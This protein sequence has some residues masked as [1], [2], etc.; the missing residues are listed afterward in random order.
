MKRWLTIGAICATFWANAETKQVSVSRI[1]EKVNLNGELDEAFW[2]QCQVLSD[3]KQY[4]PVAGANA[5]RQT[6][7]RVVY[8]NTAIYIGAEMID[9]RDSMSLTL[10]QRDDFGNADY[11]GVIVD[12]YNAGTIG[13]AFFVTSSGVQ[14]DQLHESSGPDNNWNAVWKSEVSVQDDRWTAEIKIPFSAI[15]FPKKVIQTWGINFMRSIRRKREDSYWNFYDPKGVNLI[16]QLGVVHGIENVD[17][18]LR[19]SFSPYV[20]GYVENFDGNTGYTLNG[21]MDLKYGLNEAFTLDM[22]LIPDFGQVQFDNQVLNLSPFEVRFNENRQFFTEGTELFNK[23]GLFYSRRVGGAPLF[24]NAAFTALDSN[25]IVRENPQT[26][27]LINATKLSGRTKTGTGIALFNAV[28]SSVNAVLTDTLTQTDRQFETGP[29]SN[30]NVFVIDQNL[31]NNSTVT[32]TNTNVMRN[33]HAYD[34]NVTALG[35][36]LYTKNLKYNASASVAFSQL[37]GNDSTVFGYKTTVRLAKSRGNLLWRLNYGESN[38]TYNQND[39]GFQQN[40]NTRNFSALINYNIFKPFWRFYRVWSS[41]EATYSRLVLPNEYASFGLSGAV[42]GTFRNFMTAGIWLEAAPLPNHDWFEPRQVGR[43][44]ETDSYYGAGGFISSDYS[45]PFALDLNVSYLAFLEPQRYS[46]SVF[47]SPRVRASDRLMII[48]NYNL[49]YAAN[50]EGAALTR[51]FEVPLIGE[52]PVFAKR[53]RLTMVNGIAAD[54]IFTNR[55][56]ITFSLRHYWSKVTYNSFYVLNEKGQF[57]DTDYVGLDESG[58]S[59]HNNNFN[60]FTIDMVYRWVF[61]PG[62]ELRLV[63]KNS[64]FNSSEVVSTTYADNLQNLVNFPATNSLSLKVLYY[65]DFWE[66]TQRFKRSL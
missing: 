52:N 66:T 17:S 8:D 10:S 46:T 54:Y 25:E 4:S 63:W 26:T 28:T 19:L 13:F 49:D 11:F 40:N 23:Q 5:S 9:E 62:S 1:Q 16:S 42:N 55:M 18:P 53:D 30:Y 44:Y 51:G 24:Y 58:V 27:Q 32:L 45:K 21:G 65:I 22:T 31:K 34:A 57:W 56:G 12:P 39:L 7:V 29:L 37:L 61:A 35:G 43:F 41:F 20:S 60:A 50:E 48:Y 15:R 3:F 36:N 2:N 64:I 47:I 59:L 6:K 33:G 38:N 14:I